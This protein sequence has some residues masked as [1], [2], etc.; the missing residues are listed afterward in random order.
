[1]THRGSA[2]HH[3]PPSPVTHPDRLSWP[4]CPC[5][6]IPCQRNH[7]IGL[8]S[9][10]LLL[11]RTQRPFHTSRPSTHLDLPHS[12]FRLL[13]QQKTIYFFFL[14]QGRLFSC[15]FSKSR[16]LRAGSSKCQVSFRP[17]EYGTFRDYSSAGVRLPRVHIRHLREQMLLKIH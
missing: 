11:F 4:R 7:T 5:L 1:M 9:K 6:Q 3:H 15:W 12:P 16:Q 17:S 10:H 2:Q 13:S 14:F 8:S